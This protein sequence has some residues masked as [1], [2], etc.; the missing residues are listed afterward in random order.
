MQHD[1]LHK[2]KKGN[3]WM[4]GAAV[5]WTKFY[6]KIRN[7]DISKWNPYNQLNYQHALSIFLCIAQVY[8]ELYEYLF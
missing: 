1:I 4:G 7:L 3:T 6:N 5:S 8:T 2:A